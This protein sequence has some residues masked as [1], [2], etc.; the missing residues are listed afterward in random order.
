MQVS[1]AGVGAVVG[2]LLVQPLSANAA[3][4]LT[5]RLTAVDA[6]APVLAVATSVPV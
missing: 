3:G 5:A 6:L 4:V 1:V 2:E